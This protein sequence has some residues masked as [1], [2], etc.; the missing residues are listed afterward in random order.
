[1]VTFVLPEDEARERKRQQNR[2][3][4]QRAKARKGMAQTQQLDGASQGSTSKIK[5]A[6][7][8]NAKRT[9]LSLEEKR[10]RHREH[11]KRYRLRQ[12]EKKQEQARLSAQSQAKEVNALVNRHYITL[13]TVL[14]NSL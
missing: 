3:Y 9:L 11:S 4:R 5:T 7:T 14:S 10:M 6:P 2:A 1:M 13:L 12:K 8:V